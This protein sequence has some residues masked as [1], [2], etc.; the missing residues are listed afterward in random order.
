MRGIQYHRLA[1][2]RCDAR[3]VWIAIAGGVVAGGLALDAVGLPSSYLFAALLLGL[4]IALA[5]PGPRRAAARSRFRAAQAVAGV[6]LGAYLQAEALRGG[7]RLARARAARLRG[8]ARA[9]P[10]G[11]RDPRA[12]DAAGPADGAARDDRR[13]RVGHRRDVR[14]ARRRRPARGVH[15]VPAGAR[16]GAADADRDRR[17]VRRRARQRRRAAAVR[18]P[19]RRA[20]GVGG[21]RRARARRRVGRRPAARHGRRAARPDDRSRAR[22]CWPAR[23]RASPC[24]TCSGRRRSR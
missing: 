10:R 1:W 20:V 7:R 19:A 18:G 2:R 11:R 21:D 9:Q 4:A 17:A 13:R 3:R 12:H 22:S 23:S 15:A 14:R 16:R 24:P 8:D 5:R 6:T